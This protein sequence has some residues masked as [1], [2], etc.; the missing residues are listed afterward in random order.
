M[1]AC[2]IGALMIRIGFWGPLYWAL[3]RPLHYG[4]EAIRKVWILCF[5]RCPVFDNDRVLRRSPH[6]GH[7]KQDILQNDE[8]SGS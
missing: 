5:R 7:E 3:F 4:Q 8:R 2:N 6:I 1:P